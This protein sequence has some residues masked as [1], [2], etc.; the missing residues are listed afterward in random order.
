MS[1]VYK[2]NA[3]FSN[4]SLIIDTSCLNIFDS[5][6][7]P[8]L[9]NFVAKFATKLMSLNVFTTVLWENILVTVWSRIIINGRNT[10]TKNTCGKEYAT[11][12]F[13]SLNKLNQKL[14]QGGHFDPG[15]E[16][17]IGIL[18]MAYP[19]SFLIKPRTTTIETYHPKCVGPWL[20]NQSIIKKN[21]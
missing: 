8:Q 10:M 7:Q 21:P 19:A 17:L 4:S 5:K 20:I 15:G 14:K 13:T 6:N 16:L 12:S 11:Y 18:L 9:L 2:P 1:L 3:V